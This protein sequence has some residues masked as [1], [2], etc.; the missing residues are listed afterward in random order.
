MSYKCL[1][2]NRCRP[3]LNPTLPLLSVNQL[4]KWHHH[5]PNCSSLK[6]WKSSLCCTLN[7]PLIN[8]S[9][10]YSVLSLFHTQPLHL[11]LLCHD[12]NQVNSA[13]CLNYW[14][15]LQVVFHLNHIVPPPSICFLLP[16]G[17]LHKL[18]HMFTMEYYAA[19]KKNEI[20]LSIL[21]WND[22]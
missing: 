2:L 18:Q 10:H 13:S 5:P 14:H 19:I 11:H 4:P 12:L 6:G 3:N 1:Q 20:V 7:M 22:S 17:W 9:S 21:P 8:R 15:G 16:I